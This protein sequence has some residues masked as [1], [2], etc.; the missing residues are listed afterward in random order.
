VEI[1]SKPCVITSSAEVLNL[2][3]LSASLPGNAF[4]SDFTI[5]ASRFGTLSGIVIW[6]DAELSED[7]VLTTSPFYQATHWKQTILYLAEAR[8]VADSDKVVGSIA[9]MPHKTNHRGL[10]I[11]LQLKDEVNGKILTQ[12]FDLI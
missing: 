1:C 11:T 10:T 7:V 2:D 8:P 3:L 12:A 4:K 9:M 6:F 5:E